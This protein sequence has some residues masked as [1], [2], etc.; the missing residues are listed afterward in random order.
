MQSSELITITERDT[1][2]EGDIIEGAS[3]HDHSQSVYSVY[4]SVAV[5]HVDVERKTPPLCIFI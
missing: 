2:A 4:H 1:R 5:N 3:S